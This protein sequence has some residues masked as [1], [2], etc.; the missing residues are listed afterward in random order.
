MGQTSKDYFRGEEV[1][2]DIHDKLREIND[3]LLQ[4]TP[5]TPAE[6]KSLMSEVAATVTA[7]K[8]EALTAPMGLENNATDFSALILLQVFDKLDDKA[9]VALIRSGLESKAMSAEHELNMV[10][11]HEV[12][13]LR[14]WLAKASIILVGIVLT[15]LIT[16]TTIS[17]FNE[18]RHGEQVT[19]QSTSVLSGLF[20]FLLLILGDQSK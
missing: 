8:T 6:D 4:Q 20:E 17:S 3:L 2:S 5:S 14:S 11:K 9:K 18:V 15:L 7:V 19:A 12:V 10:E 1:M 13:R 16:S